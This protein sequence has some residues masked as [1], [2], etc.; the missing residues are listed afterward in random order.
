MEKEKSVQLEQA[1]RKIIDTN[2]YMRYL[3]VEMLKLTEG[4]GLGRMRYKEELLNPYGMLHGGS[5]YS[6]ADIIAGAVACMGGHFVTTV[7]GNMNFLLPADHTE[8]VYCEAIQLRQGKHLAVFD[9][10]IKDDENRVLDSGE[11]TFFLTEH[12]VIA[13]KTE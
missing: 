9:V 2:S 7:S 1:M 11:F 13:Q 4:Y 3:G 10:K 8:F 5:L 12:E 6:L